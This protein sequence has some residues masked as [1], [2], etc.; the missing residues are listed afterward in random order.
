MIKL[1]IL[2]QTPSKKNTHMIRRNRGKTWISP[3]KTYQ[4][5]EDLA[6]LQL[7]HQRNEMELTM[8][9][10]P[11]C[12]KFLIYR[13]GKARVDLSNLIQSCED[14]LER[15]RIIE[16]DCQIESLGQQGLFS[17]SESRESENV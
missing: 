1:T 10:A 15:A 16:N 4:Q 3:S 17:Q 13:A 14:A 2:G 12:V 7:M 8:I 5:W 9:T 11:V 6:V